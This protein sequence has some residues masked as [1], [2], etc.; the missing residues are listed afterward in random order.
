MIIGLDIL[1]YYGM[2]QGILYDHQPVTYLRSNKIVSICIVSV[3]ALLVIVKV[4]WSWPRWNGYRFILFFNDFSVLHIL[5][6]E[7][8][9]KKVVLEIVIIWTHI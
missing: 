4:L 5:L 7:R 8:L 6:F 3:V 2:K 1:S 9:L